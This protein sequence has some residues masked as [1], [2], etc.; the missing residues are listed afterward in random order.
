[1]LLDDLEDCMNKFLRTTLNVER[2]QEASSDERYCHRLKELGW[3]PLFLRRLK[4]SLV[5]AY[6]I[7]LGESLFG[8]FIPITT[9]SAVAANT[10]RM[11]KILDHPKAVPTALP[12]S[13]REW[14]TPPHIDLLPPPNS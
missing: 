6:K 1:M 9:A 11:G 14:N 4:Q 10:R 8:P 13:A 7:P 2:S 12:E 3:E 5:L